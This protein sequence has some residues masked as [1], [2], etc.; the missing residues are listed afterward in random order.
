LALTS[1]QNQ[2]FV[3]S[4]LQELIELLGQNKVASDGEYAAVWGKD[5]TDFETMGHGWLTVVLHVSDDEATADRVK[6]GLT[7][8][9]EG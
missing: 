2:S 9:F 7:S 3:L 4:G 1:D 8:Y 5:Y 6:A